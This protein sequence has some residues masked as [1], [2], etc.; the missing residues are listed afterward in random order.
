MGSLCAVFPFGRL[1]NLRGKGPIWIRK[2]KMYTEHVQPA[3][4]RR[5]RHA[6][7]S[8]AVRSTVDVDSSR[9]ARAAG[10]HEEVKQFNPAYSSHD[11]LGDTVIV[12]NR[13]TQIR[14]ALGSEMSEVD[15]LYERLKKFQERRGTISTGSRADVEL[16]ARAPVNKK[17]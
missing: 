13:K 9:G 17:R 14:E 10:N 3:G 11:R 2:V 5:N 8:A 7:I 16:L 4:R 15:E 6:A 1:T 12:G